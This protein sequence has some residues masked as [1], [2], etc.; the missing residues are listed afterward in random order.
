MTFKSEFIRIAGGPLLYYTDYTTTNL[1][2]AKSFGNEVQTIT[3]T[4]DSPTDTVQIS[5]DGATL[6][7]DIKPAESLTLEV[8][9]K[10]SIYV[11]AT[12]GGGNVRLWAW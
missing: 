3:I 7:S 5:F 4:N 6:E 12:A 11:K 2:V 8:A 10:S 9:G 1:Y